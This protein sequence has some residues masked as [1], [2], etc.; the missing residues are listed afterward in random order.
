MSICILIKTGFVNNFVVV[1]VG[2]RHFC[3]IVPLKV[4]SKGIIWVL[5]LRRV[6]SRMIVN[7]TPLVYFIR[8][9]FRLKYR[10]AETGLLLLR[11]YIITWFISGWTTLYLSGDGYGLW[12]FSKKLSRYLSL[13][14]PQTGGLVLCKGLASCVP[15]P[16]EHLSP[17]S[18][19]DSRS[20]G[21]YF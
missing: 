18:N 17:S 9:L 5:D 13:L 19:H 1:S 2:R 12:Y 14:V 15:G 8:I 6:M 7:C 10:D 3:W 21:M 16:G 11:Y 4:V 20:L